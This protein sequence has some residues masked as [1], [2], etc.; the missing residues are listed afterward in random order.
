[1]HKAN[2]SW[3]RHCVERYRP[4]FHG[5]NKVLEVGSLNVNGSVRQFFSGQRGYVGVDWRPGPNVDVV[6]LAHEMLFDWPFSTVISASMFEHD[7]YWKKSLARMVGHMRPRGILL[8]SWGAARNNPHRFET[9]PDGGFHPLPVGRMLKALAALGM[10]VHE[11]RYEHLSE[12]TTEEDRRKLD[13]GCCGLAAF[14]DAR[15]APG[16][17]FH[18]DLLPEDEA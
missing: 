2:L 5:P 4:W 17:P 12:F 15:V 11:F 14:R 18:H 6:S 16:E 1:L 10:Y 7:P 3:W 8:I 9:A 13:E